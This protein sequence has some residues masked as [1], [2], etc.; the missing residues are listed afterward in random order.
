MYPVL[1]LRSE[2]VCLVILI[3]LFF[4]SRNY[5]IDKESK[6]F[7]R[8]LCFAMLHVVFDIITVI[9]VNN[10]ET[11]PNWINWFCHVVFY[12]TAMLFSNE[13]AMY[14]VALCYPKKVKK[15]Y[16][17]GHLI[18]S[19]FIL[20]L[21]F[22]DIEYMEVV[23]TYSSAGTAAY[24]G[25]SIAFAFFIAALVIIFTHFR[26]IP[27]SVKSALIPMML[28]L[29]CTEVSQV[30]WRSILF[31]GGAVTIVTVGFFFSL[32]NPVE[33]F[34][35]KAM[36][37]ALTGVQSRSSYEEEIE[38]LDEHFAANRSQDYTFVF[39]DLNDL[40]NVNNRFGHAEGDNYITLITASIKECMKECNS[41]FRIGGD[42]FLIYYYKT[43]EETVLKEI[44]SLQDECAKASENLKYTAAV[45][46]GYAVSSDVYKTLKDVVKNA[47]YAMY[48]NKAKIK[49]GTDNSNFAV[50]AKLN[51]AGLTDSI[52]DAMCAS[53]DRNYPFIT[54]LE[55]NVTRIAP[56]WKEYFGLEDEFFS[57]FVNQ[58]K[59]RIHP[60]DYDGYIKDV[61]SV[62]NGH[63]KYHN[64]EYRARKAD[65]E[66]VRVS[67]HGSVFR[68]NSNG[69][70]YFTGFI[71]NHGMDDN[72][73][74]VTGLSN[75]DILA[76][77][78]L[79]Y[80]DE[81]TPFSLIKIKLNNFARI[82][83]LYGYNEGNVI[84]KR[85]A[86]VLSGELL[87]KG[88]VF[89]HGAV[90][91]TILLRT[92]N[93]EF[94]TKYYRWISDILEVGVQTERYMVPIQ[95][96]GG[97]YVNY[98]EKVKVERIRSSLVYAVDESNYNQRCR[99]VFCND[100]DEN[101]IESDISLLAEIHSD[102]LIRM[103]NF[104]LRYQPI[105]DITTEKII[106]AEALLRWNHPDQ[107][108]IQPNKF[109]QFL[110]NDPCYYRLGLRII[111]EAVKDAKGI[112]K[113][114]PDFKINVNITALQLQNENFVKNIVSILER[115]EFEPKNLVLE[116]T[117]RCKEM[118]GAFLA[119]KI[120]SIRK[121]GIKVAF[122]DLG[123][124]YSSI[125][126]LMDIPVDEVKLDKDFVCDIPNRDSYRIFVQSLILGCTVSEGYTICFEGVETRET[127]DVIKGFGPFYA[128]GYY[129]AK[130]LEIKELVEYIKK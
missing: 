97:A 5:N 18:I 12:V 125:N 17:V 22:M 11:I 52:F 49:K 59:E 70:T 58:W 126:L 8:I 112:Q 82:N 29:M 34:R 121:T 110:E 56:A 48:Q 83:M 119:D 3:F 123:T 47:D 27:T 101:S 61:I 44:K 79:K 87:E 14:A 99:L 69:T 65:G 68:D 7:S 28:V 129:F 104:S 67:C 103:N 92:T 64:Y 84:L 78:V 91:F 30:I 42:E 90:N 60:D 124:G 122:D 54:N 9:T 76:S 39:C 117:E 118:D 74:M 63:K 127:L 37:D 53:N 72:T 31:T 106:G 102:A 108:E 57:D 38:R 25:Y 109:I 23:G 13:I 94:L 20:S 24:V 41:V 46:V 35:K 85:I 105:I 88:E 6:S 55:T 81:G 86:D 32:E 111:E 33:V 100:I 80:M 21:S 128:Q 115:H 93:E 113:T 16:P 98:G 114:I 15:I 96:S 43:G 120:S 51:Y 95:I 10:M 40:R 71:V 45:S 2:F 26:Q 4:M 36:T 62:I 89:C 75:F 1:I 116:L 50:G 107:G 130:P 66:Y 77:D 73:D 19:L